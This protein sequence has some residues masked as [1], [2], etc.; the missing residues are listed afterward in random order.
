MV[1]ALGFVEGT[2]LCKP[3]S[4]DFVSGEAA[5]RLVSLDVQAIKWPVQQSVNLCSHACALMC[6][7]ELCRSFKPLFVVYA[8]FVQPVAAVACLMFVYLL[9][10]S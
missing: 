4:A 3:Q 8:S 5:Q 2:A 7:R 6:A 9:F 1:G 10:I